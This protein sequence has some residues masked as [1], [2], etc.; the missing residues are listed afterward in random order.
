MP[1]GVKTCPQCKTDTGPRSFFC[2]ECK[3]DFKIVSKT[4]TQSTINQEQVSEKVIDTDKYTAPLPGVVY[5]TAPGR[6]KYDT[7][8]LYPCKPESCNE[9]HIRVWIEKMED[10]RFMCQGKTA[11]YTREAVV[12]L[13]DEFFP[14]YPKDRIE[15]GPA[16]DYLKAK[17]YVLKYMKPLYVGDC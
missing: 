16:P 9:D 14:M 4:A 6:S 12:Y 11:M 15:P 5:I 17:E 8:P 1:R 3:Y 13:L 7:T 10:Y 2:P